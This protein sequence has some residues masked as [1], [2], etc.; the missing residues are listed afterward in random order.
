MGVVEGVPEPVVDH[1]VD[2]LGVA[3]ARPRTAWHQAQGATLIDSMPPGDQQ[4]G[5]AQLDVLGGGGD[6]VQPRGRPC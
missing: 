1:G 3:H 5:L 4:P 6:G 2:Q